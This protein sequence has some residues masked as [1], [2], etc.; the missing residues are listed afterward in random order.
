ML[1]WLW[2]DTRISRRRRVQPKDGYGLNMR[3]LAPFG[4]L[5]V[6]AACA[7]SSIPLWPH[8]LSSP[9]IDLFRFWAI[10]AVHKAYLSSAREAFTSATI[11]SSLIGSAPAAFSAGAMLSKRE[12]LG[13][14]A[15]LALPRLVPALRCLFKIDVPKFDAQVSTYR[16]PHDTW[17]YRKPSVSGSFTGRLGQSSRGCA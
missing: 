5:L 8:A 9:G 3:C 10:G 4:L 2:A 13:T 7:I 14:P 12:Y 16:M 15:I 17:R 1:K 6:I 11:S